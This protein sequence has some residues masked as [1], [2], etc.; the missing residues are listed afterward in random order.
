M[1]DILCIRC[2]LYFTGQYILMR[3]GALPRLWHYMTHLLTYLYV[4]V[5]QDLYSKKCGLT[6]HK[7]HTAPSLD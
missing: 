1:M 7:V 3:S 6:A 2:E 4:S 5:A